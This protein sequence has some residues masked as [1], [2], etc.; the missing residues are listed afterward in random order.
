MAAKSEARVSP[1]QSQAPHLMRA[2]S[3]RRL[4]LR[5]SS[6]LPD[7]IKGWKGGKVETTSLAALGGGNTIERDYR[8]DEKKA[9]VSIAAAQFTSWRWSRR[10]AR[11]RHHR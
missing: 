6:V 10:D 11:T 7:E 5:L 1:K 4:S 8:K 2:S 3:T 9:T